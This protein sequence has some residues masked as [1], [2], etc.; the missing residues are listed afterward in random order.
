[1]DQT[2]KCTVIAQNNE[3]CSTSIRN[4]KNCRVIDTLNDSS[5]DVICLSPPDKNV[6]PPAQRLISPS[7]QSDSP[8]AQNFIPTTW[9]CFF[10]GC[11]FVALSKAK[12]VNHKHM[13]EHFVNYKKKPAASVTPTKT[14]PTSA[15]P[16]TVTP[17]AN[18]LTEASENPTSNPVQIVT[19]EAPQSQTG[20]FTTKL[21]EDKLT[22]STPIAVKPSKIERQVSPLDRATVIQDQGF[23]VQYKNLNS[24]ETG[25]NR[26][27]EAG[28]TSSNQLDKNSPS[29][30]L[31]SK[32][33]KPDCQVSA[34]QLVKKER[35]RVKNQKKL[36]VK[37]GSN[38]IE[39]Q[40]QEKNFDKPDL[41]A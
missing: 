29:K 24:T 26:N 2:Q 8:A 17:A 23:P 6:C 41:E 32:E 33:K 34:N 25:S 38:Q 1:M 22:L 35:E 7:D 30:V 27:E 5:N 19:F 10:E 36:K 16:T 31:T 3:A 21:A 18:T 39:F 40:N 15:T 37:T 11:G 9:S 28:G 20:E 13:F 14:P 4:N 12:L